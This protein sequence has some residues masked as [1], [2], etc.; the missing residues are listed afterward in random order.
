MLPVLFRIV[1]PAG[2]GKPL[3]VVLFLA[4]AVGR[5]RAY[6]L[7][8][9]RE[10]PPVGFG[11]ALKDDAW[12]FALLAAVA[13]VLW[14]GGLLDEAIRLPLHTYGLLIATGF[15]VGIGLAQREARRRGQDPE[16]IADLAFWI[17]V[18]ALV[19]SR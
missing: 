2:W 13:G 15:L 1:I 3:A 11:A 5:A 8:S 17:L 12:V 10:G 19:G 7:R 18:A 16:A 9:R 14:R 6:V 4:I